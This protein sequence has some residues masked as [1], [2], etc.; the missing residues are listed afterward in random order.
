MSTGF[1]GNIYRF[2][3]RECER[4]VFFDRQEEFPLR[5]VSFRGQELDFH[6]YTGKHASGWQ[7]WSA[8]TPR[9]PTGYGLADAVITDPHCCCCFVLSRCASVES[10]EN[11]A[12][13]ERK[14]WRDDFVNGIREGKPIG[15]AHVCVLVP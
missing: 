3:T 1:H 12:Q 13:K 14:A 15:F 10:L 7:P 11:H 4:A 9:H 5:W 8:A 6:A 2:R